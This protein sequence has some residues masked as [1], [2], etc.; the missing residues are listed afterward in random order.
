[1]K[2]SEKLWRRLESTQ[3][4]SFLL[5]YSTEMI[6]KKFDETTVLEISSLL[7]SMA[8]YS[9][10]GTPSKLS[11]TFYTF[12]RNQEIDAWEVH[13]INSEFNLGYSTEMI[14]VSCHFWLH[15][16]D[17]RRFQYFQELH[18][19]LDQTKQ[20]S[21]ETSLES[22]QRSFFLV[23]DSTGMIINNFDETR[24]MEISNRL[25]TLPTF[26]THS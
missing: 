19:R 10:F 26:S 8:S 18:I 22:T 11:T 6:T 5:G 20:S 12:R 1:M 3:R 14:I 25:K 17:I 21:L 24:V 9:R 16:W 7:I 15:I 2:W 4:S 13:G 23:G